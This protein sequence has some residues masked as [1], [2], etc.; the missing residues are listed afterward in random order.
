[1]TTRIH[2]RAYINSLTQRAQEY[3]IGLADVAHVQLERALAISQLLGVRAR[4]IADV[5]LVLRDASLSHRVEVLE[6]STNA[7]RFLFSESACA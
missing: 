2:A 3:R 1:M 4:L 6:L 5:L 7:K